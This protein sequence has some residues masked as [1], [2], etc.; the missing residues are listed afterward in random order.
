[1]KKVYC[2]CE[3]VNK[4]H[5]KNKDCL[6]MK[7]TKSTDGDTCDYCGYYV[8]KAK[9]IICKD[10][11]RSSSVLPLIPLEVN[12]GNSGTYKKELSQEFFRELLSSSIEEVYSFKG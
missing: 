1:M 12:L 3:K 4:I 7:A 6:G 8:T 9:V 10:K 11:S 5:K 2:N